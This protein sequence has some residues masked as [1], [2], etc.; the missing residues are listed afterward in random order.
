MEKGTA[1]ADVTL[2]TSVGQEPGSKAM[3]PKGFG[4]S[5]NTNSANQD[6][7]LQLDVEGNFSDIL[8]FVYYLENSQKLIAVSSIDIDQVHTLNPSDA[9]NNQEGSLGDLKASILVTNVF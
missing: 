6:V 2:I 3:F 8:K 9:L 5:N 1:A 7:W 4:S